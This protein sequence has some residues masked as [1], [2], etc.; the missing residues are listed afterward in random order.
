MTRPGMSDG[1]AFGDDM[2]LMSCNINGKMKGNMSN[3]QYR[4]YLMKNAEKV[5]KMIK[6]PINEPVLQ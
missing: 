6:T 1:R 3:E 4:Q 5:K 2:Y